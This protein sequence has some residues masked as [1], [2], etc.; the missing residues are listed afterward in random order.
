MTPFIHEYEEALTRWHSARKNFPSLD[1][2]PEPKPE[3][4]HFKT[5]GDLWLAGNIRDRLEREM[6]RTA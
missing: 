3:D 2:G 4:F 5:I 6:K 1:H